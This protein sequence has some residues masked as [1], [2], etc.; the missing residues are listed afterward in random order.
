VFAAQLL[1]AVGGLTDG[2]GTVGLPGHLL[3]LGGEFGDV[4]PPVRDEC[5][6][7]RK[8]GADAGL[9]DMDTADAGRA[10]L[11]WRRQLVEGLVGDEGF[12]DAA[13]RNRSSTQSLKHLDS[14]R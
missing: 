3:D 1:R 5:E 10:D 6:H 2:V 11:G 13:V 4:K 12:V 7:G 14:L 8:L 9:V